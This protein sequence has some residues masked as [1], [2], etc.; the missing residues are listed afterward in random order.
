[1]LAPI[2]FLN[3]FEYVTQCFYSIVIRIS[4]AVFPFFLFAGLAGYYWTTIDMEVK[5]QNNHTTFQRVFHCTILHSSA[6]IFWA[7]YI[8]FFAIQFTHLTFVF[9][10]EDVKK[11]KLYIYT[12]LINLQRT[13]LL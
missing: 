9:Y 11:L 12:K 8:A 5:L 3:D 10:P 7:F 1:M 2:L 13:M 6:K 4:I